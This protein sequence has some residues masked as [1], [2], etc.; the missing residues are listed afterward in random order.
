MAMLLEHYHVLELSRQQA[1]VLAL[2]VYPKR[3]ET[4]LRVRKDMLNAI[5]VQTV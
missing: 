5:Q 2:T 1:H 4:D 3:P